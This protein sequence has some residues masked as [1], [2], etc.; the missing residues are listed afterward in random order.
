MLRLKLEC[1]EVQEEMDR[2]M[3]DY[4]KMAAVAV[5]QEEQEHLL[6]QQSSEAT[7]TNEGADLVRNDVFCTHHLCSLHPCPIVSASISIGAADAGL[8]CSTRA[9]MHAHRRPCLKQTRK[10][11]LGAKWTIA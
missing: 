8:G 3:A 11:A 5:L 9:H 1:Q 10:D 7:I 2:L 6:Q 4:Q